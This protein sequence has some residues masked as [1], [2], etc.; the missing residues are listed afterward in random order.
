MFGLLREKQNNPPDDIHKLIDGSLQ[1]IERLAEKK[2]LEQLRLKYGAARLS[3]DMRS[4]A[5][6]Q[7]KQDLFNAIAKG[8]RPVL[9]R[10]LTECHS[11]SGL[12]E[13]MRRN[14]VDSKNI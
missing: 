7:Y 5:I 9:D 10:V 13:I 8:G 2:A 6:D 12:H 1:D 11:S 14:G 4:A 3:S